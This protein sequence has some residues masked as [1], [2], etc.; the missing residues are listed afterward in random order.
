MPKSVGILTMSTIY[1][2]KMTLQLQMSVEPQ[3]VTTDPILPALTYVIPAVL[4]YAN[5]PSKYL[6]A[7]DFQMN[8]SSAR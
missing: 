5:R 7:V 3:S 6:H 2:L 1:L 8:A 4:L